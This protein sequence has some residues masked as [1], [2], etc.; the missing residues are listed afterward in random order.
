MAQT[1][2]A[3]AVLD[4]GDLDCGSGLLLLI[5]E[6][7]APLAP[8]GVL[9]LRSR[10]ISVREDLPAWCR[11]VGHAIV[12]DVPGD[13][14]STSWFLRKQSEDDKLR[15]DFAAARD[16]AWKT[17]VKWTGGLAAKAYVRN[18]AFAVG[19]PASFD[20][21]DPA[22]GAIE[23][24]LSALAGCLTV[25]FAWRASRRGIEVRN[26]EVSL[27]AKSEDI[28]GFLGVE[29]AGN[30]GLARVEG[31][32]FVDADADA[33]VLEELWAETVARSPVAQTLARRVDVAV[34]L[35]SV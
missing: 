15:A 6:A 5:R 21:A 26:L 33:A 13:G 24:L 32:A 27:S 20:T 11:M 34:T 31:T 9:E 1:P 8:G 16:F 23:Y 18:H 29:G 35:R 10:E 22:P 4:G 12:A 19:Q 3:D 17:R 14:G 30:P 2:R 7:M 25:G 28:L